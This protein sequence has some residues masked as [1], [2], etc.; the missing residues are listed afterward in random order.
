MAQSKRTSANKV[1][2]NLIERGMESLRAERE[3]FFALADRLVKTK[4]V[5]EQK[6]IKE[7]L[8]RLTFGA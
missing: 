6:Q 2:L 3:R 5:E 7:E 8:A 1:L 4:D